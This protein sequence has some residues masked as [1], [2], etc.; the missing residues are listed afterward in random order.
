M[1][2]VRLG[3]K[4][5]DRGYRTIG[6][7][8]LVEELERWYGKGHARKWSRVGRFAVVLGIRKRSWRLSRG[9][10]G[11]VQACT[12]G[13]VVVG[14]DLLEEVVGRSC[15]AGELQF[16]GHDRSEQRLLSRYQRRLQQEAGSSLGVELALE[17][18]ERLGCKQEEYVPR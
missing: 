6:R 15:A 9:E 3:G 10:I 8:A 4:E 5:V 17:L 18:E 2:H 16:H 12:V 1:K 11:V 13:S 14:F 7:N